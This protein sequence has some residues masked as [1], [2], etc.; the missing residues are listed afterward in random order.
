MKHT[1]GKKI[2]RRKTKQKNP[3]QTIPKQNQKISLC[4]ALFLNMLDGIYDTWE[5]E[6][7]L[8]S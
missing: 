8:R 5:K 4:I 6:M 2:S 1:L 7:M 3:N